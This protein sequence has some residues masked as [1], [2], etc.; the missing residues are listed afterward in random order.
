ML[1]AARRSLIQQELESATY[2]TTSDLSSRLDVDV[3]T[4]RR[5]LIALEREG[6]LVRRHGGAMLV[7]SR[8]D[9]DIPYSYKATLRTAEK[10]AIAARAAAMVAPGEIVIV[11]S[12]ST[13]FEMVLALR[14]V[15]DLTVVTNDLQIARTVADIEGWRLLVTGGALMEHVYTLSGEAAVRFFEDV[16]ADWTFLGA[17]AVDP[18]LG[19]TNSNPQEAQVKRAMIAA[20]NETV[21]LADSSKLNRRSVSPVA[22]IADVKHLITDGGLDVDSRA[23]YGPGLIIVDAR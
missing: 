14:D 9:A 21:I 13:T 19:V 15:S 18:R 20:S 12:G 23:A 1:T 3:S 6:I 11:D 16:R 2:V 22:Q 4:V 17:D 8:T 7:D 10:T 5:D